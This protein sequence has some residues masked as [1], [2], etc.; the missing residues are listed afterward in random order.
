MREIGNNMDSEDI[1]VEGKEWA[2]NL[3]DRAIPTNSYSLSLSLPLPLHPL[4][5]QGKVESLLKAFIFS[6]LC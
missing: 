4:Q 6:Q 3:R 1:Q 5:I 2:T